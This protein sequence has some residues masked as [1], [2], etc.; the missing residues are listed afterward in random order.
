MKGLNTRK[1]LS[2]LSHLSL[3]AKVKSEAPSC[4][5]ELWDSPILQLQIINIDW[6]EVLCILTVQIKG[7]QIGGSQS[8]YQRDGASHLALAEGFCEKSIAQREGRPNNLLP[9]KSCENIK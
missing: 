1:E 8:L 5:V 3:Y 2:H 7:C 9:V 4:W 6:K